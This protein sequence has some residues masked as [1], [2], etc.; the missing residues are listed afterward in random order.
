MP[1]LKQLTCTLEKE[2][3]RSPLK[4]FST[5]YSDGF[6]EAYVAVPEQR[7]GFSLN[8]RSNGYIAPGLAIFVYIDG[9]YQCN[10]HRQGLIPPDGTI[11]SD[12]YEVNFRV[13]QKEEKIAKGQFVGRAWSFDSLNI[14]TADKAP[15]VDD[16]ILGNLGTI[17]VVVL[18]TKAP[19][20]EPAPGAAA[21][22]LPA[23][24]TS[25]NTGKAGKQKAVKVKPKLAP[26]NGTLDGT[27]DFVAVQDFGAGLDGPNDYRHHDQTYDC[28]YH[29]D[30]R[31][32]PRHSHDSYHRRASRSPPPPRDFGPSYADYLRWIATHPD[33]A[34]P[35]CGRVAQRSSS[36][37]EQYRPTDVER[38]QHGETPIT[39]RQRRRVRASDGIPQN[40]PYEYWVFEGSNLEIG[41]CFPHA[42]HKPT[43]SASVS[44]VAS[45]NGSEAARRPRT[46]G[47]ARRGAYSNIDTRE[48]ARVRASDQV[49]L[50]VR[51]DGSRLSLEGRVTDPVRQIPIRSGH[52]ANVKDSS[53]RLGQE[54]E[55]LASSMHRPDPM[56]N[57]RYP[58]DEATLQKHRNASSRDGTSKMPGGWDDPKDS[59]RAPNPFEGRF[60]DNEKPSASHSNRGELTSAFDDAGW[61]IANEQGHHG[62]GQSSGQNW[63]EVNG[64]GQNTAG[65]GDNHQNG[66]SGWNGNGSGGAGGNAGWGATG[67]QEQATQQDT[68]ASAGWGDGNNG[69][70]SFGANNAG[71]SGWEFNTAGNNA[72]TSGCQQTWNN[73][74]WGGGADTTE[75]NGGR[76]VQDDA[77]G[78]AADNTGGGWSQDNAGFDWS[79]PADNT[80]QQTPAAKNWA[81]DAA[82]ATAAA[83]APAVQQFTAPAA[84][85]PTSSHKASGSKA[86]S[87]SSAAAA[88]STRAHKPVVPDQPFIKSYWQN[89]A[90]RAP[91][92]APYPQPKRSADAA[93][94]IFA[95]SEAPYVVPERTAR[96][97][98][99]DSYVHHGKA[100]GYAHATAR[101]AYMDTLE[102]PYAVFRFKY[103]SGEMLARILGRRGK[104]EVERERARER[105]EEERR[106]LAGLSREEL[107]E[108]L[109]AE[110]KGKE[111]EA[112]KSVAGGGGGS[113]KKAGG[114]QQ[115]ASSVGATSQPKPINQWANEVAVATG[116][117]GKGKGA[118]G[119]GEALVCDRCKNALGS[120][121]WSC[122][123][124]GGDDDT[125]DI[126]C[127]CVE[128]KKRCKDSSH[129]LMKWKD[130]VTMVNGEPEPGPIIGEILRGIPKG[131][132]NKGGKSV[133]S[134]G[135]KNG[136]GG[137]NNNN[138]WSG[139][140]AGATNGADNGGGW[141][142]WPAD[143]TGGA[144]WGAVDGDAGG[145]ESKWA[146]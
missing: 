32:R 31:H 118:S 84:A 26:G 58:P 77:V 6:V 99:V 29:D 23:Q 108:R 55:S 19:S 52:G 37:Y 122:N 11:P 91:P 93:T 126:C 135:K 123:V 121:W 68:G 27:E 21:Q 59:A 127:P 136:G 75:Q 35:S 144:S 88:A 1:T 87:S 80:A 130:N 101:P 119:T 44:H 86:A 73:D 141:E 110:G 60:I 49:S 145:A 15:N 109:L 53:Y 120:E 56:Y 139:G 48:V 45:Q 70:I 78:N 107:V 51:W 36:Y 113:Q 41:D 95:P 61:D 97:K 116:S 18:R 46:S 8:L 140:D 146:I 54:D 64:A 30:R 142:S 83:A 89:T 102:S 100:Y 106:G 69:N 33:A 12:F 104:E 128:K 76:A 24:P 17:E 9:V 43:S 72:G 82:P 16:T 34:V 112:R 2:P 81:D 131:S 143:N 28:H 103:R 85:K 71:G 39:Q 10:R 65:W 125:Y 94:E 66:Q 96:E 63:F 133:A 137:N 74:N 98:L 62:G 92:A 114:S 57:P 111:K 117:V 79:T 14:A 20:A 67:I 50:H 25:G 5:N 124:C 4:E 129:D 22:I 115:K 3:S 134:G 42:A 13:S 38:N 138:N 132:K 90:P 47:D 7:T 105:A 40:K